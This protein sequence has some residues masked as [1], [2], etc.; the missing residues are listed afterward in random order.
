MIRL[1]Y[2][3]A[4]TGALTLLGLAKAD[5]FPELIR[6]GYVNCSACHVS[7]AGGG[8]LTPYG[9]G[10]SNEIVSRWGTEKETLPLHGLVP[11]EKVQDCLFL[12][13]DLRGVQTQYENNLVKDGQWIPMQAQAEVAARAGTLTYLS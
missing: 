7:P 4:L 10:L 2:L 11:L 9:R 8:V 1:T 12:G 3:K 6:H 13:G 5:A